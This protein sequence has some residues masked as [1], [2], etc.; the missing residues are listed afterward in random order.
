MEVADA[1]DQTAS[2]IASRTETPLFNPTSYT[3]WPSVGSSNRTTAQTLALKGYLIIN[4]TDG[5]FGQDGRTGIVGLGHSLWLSSQREHM[6]HVRLLIADGHDVVRRGVR[7]ILEDNPNWKIVA[8]A[9]DG[10]QAIEKANE[11]KPDVAILDFS[12]GHPIRGGCM[13]LKLC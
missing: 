11:F 9:S 12:A 10:Q 8:E 7:T 5:L 2:G 6:P 1:R 4:K 13:T 3:V